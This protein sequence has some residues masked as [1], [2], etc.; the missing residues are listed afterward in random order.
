[1]GVCGRGN[2]IK[3]FFFLFVYNGTFE[4]GNVL[5][6]EVLETAF[7]K[8]SLPYFSPTAYMKA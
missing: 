4:I 5:G 2:F 1:M 8:S 6:K 3:E 7:W